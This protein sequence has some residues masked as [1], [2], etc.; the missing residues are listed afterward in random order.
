V[1]KELMDASKDRY[2]SLYKIAMIHLGLGDKEQAFDWLNKTGDDHSEWFA[3]VK[4]DP[5]LDPLRSDP[6]F[7]GLLRRAG[8]SADK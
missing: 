2:L 7:N 3:S 5:R 4:V 8:L 6:R 1:L